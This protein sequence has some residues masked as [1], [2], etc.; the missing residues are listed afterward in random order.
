MVPLG[1][2][3]VDRSLQGAQAGQRVVYVVTDIV[4]PTIDTASAA[5]KELRDNVQKTA[6]NEQLMQ[7]VGKLE[8]DIGAKINTTAFAQATGAQSGN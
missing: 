5:T 4:E 6:A 8:Q 2:L 3:E 7:F 1:I